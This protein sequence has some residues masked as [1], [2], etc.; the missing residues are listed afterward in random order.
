MSSTTWFLFHL[1][2]GAVGAWTAYG[3]AR[4]R[5][6]LD[7]PGERRSHAVPTPRGGGAAIA[8][9][10]LVATAWLAWRMP[11]QGLLLGGFGVGLALV[12][13]VGWIDDHRPL[14]AWTRLAVHVVAGGVFALGI[15]VQS[16]QGLGALVAFGATVVLVNAWNFMDGIDGLASTQAILV[17]LVLALLAGPVG[18]A[19]GIALV[20]STL[21]FLPWNFPRARLFLGDVGSGTLGFA[22]GGLVAM[23]AMAGPRALALALFPLSAFMV[24]TGLTLCRRM[25]AGER[26]WQ[27]HV[28]HAFQHAARRY[29]HVPVT[30]AFA[31]WTSAMVAVAWIC[32]DMA[33]TT[34]TISLL[35]SYA[36]GSVAWWWLRRRD[37]LAAMENKE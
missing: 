30:L 32:R 33:V 22:I 29:G 23:A 13:L 6:L 34:L 25:V 15:W 9:A 37:G 36:S 1:L 10:L 21:G 4:R 16:G 7:H 5:A 31:A 11:G 14:S 24:D 17:A 18:V 20:A 35:L 12:S 28:S 19:L 2:L 8:A 3:Y 27:A 26:W